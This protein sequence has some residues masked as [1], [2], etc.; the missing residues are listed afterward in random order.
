MASSPAPLDPEDLALLERVAARLV[1]LHLEV[2]S[3]L[4]LESGRPL[5][6]VASQSLIFFEPI[7]TALFRLDGYRRFALLVERRDA[8]D[9]LVALIE[10]RADE[11]HRA[12]RAARAAR[13]S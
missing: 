11:A 2:P 4:A 8:V 9:R 12:R 6:L 13:K 5:S 1:E 10:A 3:I 7:V